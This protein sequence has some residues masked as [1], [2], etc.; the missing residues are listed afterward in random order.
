MSP[1]IPLYS[2]PS[3]QA[4]AWLFSSLWICIGA[5]VM[6]RRF[7][8]VAYSERWL[9]SALCAFRNLALFIC[10]I[11][12]VGIVFLL[13]LKVVSMFWFFWE[14]MFALSVISLFWMFPVVVVGF[15]C[16]VCFGRF[17]NH[18]GKRSIILYWQ[19]LLAVAVDVLLYYAMQFFPQ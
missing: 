18:Y 15:S 3:D 10:I 19:C 1:Y 12:T 9:S 7:S 4:V 14:V 17:V 2:N 13:W 8:E 5:L 11:F 6:R 16:W